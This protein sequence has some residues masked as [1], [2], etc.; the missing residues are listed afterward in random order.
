[1]ELP[2]AQVAVLTAASANDAQAIETL[3]DETDLAFETVTGAAFALEESDLVAVEAIER[4]RVA[5]TD[6]GET[7]L[8]DGLPEVAL[9][10]AA[11][12]AGADE[13]PV[14]L[15]Q[16]IGAAGLGGN[17]VDI[18]LANFARKGYGSIDDGAVRADPDAD[19]EADAEAAAPPHS[20]PG[21]AGRQCVARIAG[22]RH[23]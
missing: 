20:R 21:A 12:D 7:Y 10:R 4:E 9:Y 22:L 5:L 8:A 17:A 16:V 13:E 3:A 1:M 6:E 19:P 11:V 14:S 23:V 15:G 2:A 18:A